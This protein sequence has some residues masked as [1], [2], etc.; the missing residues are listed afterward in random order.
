[1]KELL[2]KDKYYVSLRVLTNYYM[3]GYI[4]QACDEFYMINNAHY[5][6]Y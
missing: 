1:M 2:L 6:K 4:S 5:V 3:D